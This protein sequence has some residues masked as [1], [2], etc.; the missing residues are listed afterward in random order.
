M[1]DSSDSDEFELDVDA[2]PNDNQ[3]NRNN[4]QGAY[5]YH[6]YNSLETPV[7]RDHLSYKI[8]DIGPL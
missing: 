3:N 8:N 1:S 4:L 2:D 6:F 5:D 7:M